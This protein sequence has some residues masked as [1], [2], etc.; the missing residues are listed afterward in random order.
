[1]ERNSM[2][3]A[4]IALILVF[5]A[6]SAFTADKIIVKFEAYAEDQQAVLE[7]ETA[8]ENGVTGFQIQRSVDG[9]RFH[10]VAAVRPGEPN[11]SYRYVDD[12][13]FKGRVHT[14]YYRI[15]VVKNTGDKLYTN[16]NIVRLI[17]SNI[18]RTWG[19]IKAMFQ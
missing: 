13:L 7:W 9:A 1:M 5:S 8:S 3:Y 16:T 15:A 4:I 12:D 2:K 14:Y 18:H 10:T 19:S 11:N 17:S 6:T